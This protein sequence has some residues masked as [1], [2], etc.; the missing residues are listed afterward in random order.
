MA[1]ILS[2]TSSR[3]LAS[4]RRHESGLRKRRHSPTTS[5]TQRPLRRRRTLAYMRKS[6]REYD[7]ILPDLYRM[8]MRERSGTSLTCSISWGYCDNLEKCS[9]GSL[10]CTNTSNKET[11]RRQMWMRGKPSM[12]RECSQWGCLFA[13]YEESCFHNSQARSRRSV[14]WRRTN[15][16]RWAIVLWTDICF[17][18]LFWRCLLC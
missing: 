5:A 16:R 11:K 14:A 2:V 15:V 3:R 7:V 4:R 8:R 1:G 17:A 12:S 10:P 6:W 9:N 18:A 13:K